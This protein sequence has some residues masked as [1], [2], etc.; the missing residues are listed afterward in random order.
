SYVDEV[1]SKDLVDAAIGGMRDILDPHTAY[2]DAK[3]YEDLKISTEGEF[4][5]LGIQIGI[6]DQA[7]TVVSP[8]AGTPAHRM[9]LQAG[10]KITRIDTLDTRGIT[11]DDAVNKLRGKPGSKVTLR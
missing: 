5:G 7:L 10:D 9:G 8:L 6:R 2:F 11:V 1:S 4:G 3:D